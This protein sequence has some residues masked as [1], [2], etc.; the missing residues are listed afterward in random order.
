MP[1]IFLE[2]I[3]NEPFGRKKEYLIGGVEKNWV[4]VEIY[5]EVLKYCEANKATHFEKGSF[6]YEHVKFLLRKE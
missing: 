2:S 6:L 4:M 1:L 5:Q 3:G